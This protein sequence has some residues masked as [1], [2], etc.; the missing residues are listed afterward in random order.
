MRRGLCWSSRLLLFVPARAPRAQAETLKYRFGP[1]HIGARPQRRSCSQVNDQRPPVD[2]WITGFKPN[3]TYA[4]GDGPARR[5]HPPAPRRLAL[6]GAPL[7]AAG[8]EK[9]TVRAPPGYGWRY[10]TSD[11]WVMNHMIHNLTP[12]PADVYIDYELDFMPDTAPEAAAMQEVAD[13]VARRDGRSSSTRCS[14]STAAPAAATAATRTRTS[15][16]SAT[17]RATA[18][19]VPR[20]A[21]WSAPAGHLHPGGLWT[22]L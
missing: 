3:L 12:T 20:T 6:N 2:G 7:F 16:G 11:Q 21:C 9:T 13:A 10:R 4:D 22:D 14:T 5:R 19:V 18:D 1:V 15:P 8:E 17:T